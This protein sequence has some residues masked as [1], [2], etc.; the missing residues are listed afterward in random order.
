MKV[1]KGQLFVLF[2][3]LLWGCGIKKDNTPGK[4][5]DYDRGNWYH[6]LGKL[7]SAF[8]MYNRYV[9]NADDTLKKGTAYRFMGD[10]Q[11]EAGD[12]HGAEESATGAI[13]TLDTLNTEHHSELCFTYRLLGNINVDLQHYDEA[14]NMYNKAM[15]FSTEDNFPLELMNDKA[16]ALQKKGAYNKAIAIYDSVLQ[17]KISNPSLFARI[18][19]NR[20]TTKW[21]L[22]SSH[23]VLPEF[24]Q[25]LRIR[26][27]SQYHRGLNASYAHLSDY[28][29]KIKPDSALWYANKMLQQAYIIQSPADRLE[30]IDKLIKLDNAAAS[31]K[32]YNQFKKLNDS[33]QLARDTTRNRFALIRYDSQK[34]KADNLAL[35]SKVTTQRL[36]FYGLL[37]L[38]AIVIILLWSWYNKRKRRIKQAA[39]LSIRDSKLKTSQKVHDVVANGLYGIMNELEHSED[40]KRDPLLT[41][42]ESLYEK[43]RDI[44]KEEMSFADDKDYDKQIHALLNEFTNE[45]TRVFVVGNQP[46]FWNK[47]TSV[48]K[49]QLLL[50]LREIMTNMKKHSGATN[51]VVK[52]KEDNN[53]GTIS[54]SDDGKGFPADIQYGNGLNNTVNRIQALNGEIIFGKSDKGGASIAIRFPLQSSKV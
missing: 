7:D 24:W 32:W 11:W 54:Y 22:N 51:V 53:S 19:D 10:M 16:V 8:L 52:C 47:V 17:L 44:S 15:R 4:Y 43:S 1:S 40:I 29:E 50:I 20:A 33:L 18:L 45:Q 2:I 42:I 38:A 5:T 13:R 14:I 23:P 48:Q 27:D 36:W 49:D 37:G 39:E 9:D 31:K 35:K 6:H 3:L 25:A 26:T 46:V 30:A 12:L 21:R 34:S 41:R 28:Y